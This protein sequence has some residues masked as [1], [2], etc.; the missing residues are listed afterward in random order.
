MNLRDRAV[1]VVEQTLD[2]FAEASPGCA[3]GVVAN[4]ETLATGCRG[5]ANME[6]GAPITPASRF[7]LA[8]VSKQV[9][10]MAV[11]FAV[12]A[13][14][15]DL[16]GSIRKVISE[17]P[18]YIDGVTPRR[19]L[20]H[21]SGIRDYFSL[22]FLGG[23]SPEHVYT[24]SDVLEL[25]GRQQALNFAP[26]TDILYSNSG[27]VLLAIAVARA[28]GKRL[29]A[30]ARET[31][32]EPLGMA[33]SRFQH[34]HALIVPDKACGYQQRGDEWLTANSTL[35]VVG[36]G[37]M[38]AS[39]NDML[40]W[41]R[42]LLSPRVGAAAISQMKAPA[43]LSSGAPTGYGMGL[44]VGAHRGLAMVEHGGGLAGYRTQVLAYP[45]EGFGVVVL[46]NDAAAWPAQIAGQ[47]A[48][49]CLSERMTPAPA[50]AP[51]IA[52]ER[53]QARAGI[54][55]SAG[56]ELM[57][58]NERD[59]KL[60]IAGLPAPLRTLGPD[61]YALDDLHGVTM[62]FEAAD[63]AFVLSHAGGP[64]RRYASCG[65]PSDIH[66]DG[67]AGEY[68][69]AEI[70]APCTVSRIQSGLAVKLTRQ[71]AAILLA[72]APDCLWAANL[73]VTLTF[74]RGDDGAVRGFTIDGARLRG[75]TFSR[76]F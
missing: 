27:F 12:E 38:Y 52:I 74:E 32:F 23:L 4:G 6:L 37:G 54:Y 24:E 14:H 19:L 66:D 28:T 36:D 71:P 45:S 73:G 53:V 9:T 21:T 18:P 17:L 50:T 49:A 8:S 64:T 25:V 44:G 3:I 57:R 26:G 1:A 2:R 76:R 33:A 48:E 20:E 41:T 31:I 13:G 40:A 59:G 7:Y 46:C 67:Y 75:I 42:N 51:G 43:S 61:I 29:D 15:L 56:K 70:A 58:L 39:L 30:F 11:L 63:G 16:D 22:G 47:V 62:T 34:D 68:R 69:S 35:D 65:T 72:I 5:L 60:F 10:A 55:R